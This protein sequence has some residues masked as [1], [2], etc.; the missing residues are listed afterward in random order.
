MSRI[1][2]DIDIYDYMDEIVEAAMES[3]RHFN[4]IIEKIGRLPTDEM[5]TA[6]RAYEA[7]RQQD[8]EEAELLLRSI[9]KPKWASPAAEMAAYKAARQ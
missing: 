8:Y 2:V 7:M 6:K 4:K 5:E 9:I 3:P 1:S